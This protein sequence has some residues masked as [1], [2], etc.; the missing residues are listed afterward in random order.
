MEKKI[1]E[2]QGTYDKLIAVKSEIAALK[3]MQEVLEAAL[4]TAIGAG[5]TGV[6][7]GKPVA[8]WS[9]YETTVFQQKAFKEE[10][11]DTYQRYCTVETRNRFALVSEDENE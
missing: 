4:K 8:R 7:G 6:I 5:N 11:S 2:L 1:D 10:N 3:Q 9:Q